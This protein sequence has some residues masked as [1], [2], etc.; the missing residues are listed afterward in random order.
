MSLGDAANDDRLS[1]IRRRSLGLLLAGLA[2]WLMSLAIPLI[3]GASR[4]WSEEEAQEYARAGSR[5]HDL[6]EGTHD[7]SHEELRFENE[8][9]KRAY[10]ELLAT[11]D[12]RHVHVDLEELKAAHAEFEIHRARLERARSWNSG[13]ITVLFWSGIILGGVGAVGFFAAGR[14]SDD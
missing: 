14:A 6:I 7:H 11:R 5:L 8:E 2:M 4:G 12:H 1:R 9:A 13:Q 10:H 3:F